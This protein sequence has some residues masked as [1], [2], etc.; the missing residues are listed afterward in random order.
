MVFGMGGVQVP[1][2]LIS[3]SFIN[4]TLVPTGMDDG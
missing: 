1:V 2:F 3:C 4:P